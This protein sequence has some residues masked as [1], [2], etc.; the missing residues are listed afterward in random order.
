MTTCM[1]GQGYIL[2]EPTL[3]QDGEYVFDLTSTS[4]DTA[5]AAWNEAVF[6]TCSPD[7]G[8]IAAQAA[9][10]PFGAES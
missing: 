4:I 10:A 6:L 3:N 1:A 7:G 5:Q 2:P 9:D 8:Q